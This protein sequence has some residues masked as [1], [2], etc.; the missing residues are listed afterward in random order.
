MELIQKSIKFKHGRINFWQDDRDPANKY[1][2]VNFSVPYKVKNNIK[3]DIKM[4]FING[5][6]RLVCSE[7]NKKILKKCGLDFD[8]INNNAVQL[9]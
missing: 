1:V 9:W 2:F 5:E 8:S 7:E 3:H 4:K 6:R